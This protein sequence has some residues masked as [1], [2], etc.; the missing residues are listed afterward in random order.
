[1]ATNQN[2]TAPHSQINAGDEALYK[3][4]DR[5]KVLEIR[6]WGASAVIEFDNGLT[7]M[8]SIKLLTPIPPCQ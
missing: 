7:C 5:V 8:R 6:E 3:N 1:M 4:V 2:D